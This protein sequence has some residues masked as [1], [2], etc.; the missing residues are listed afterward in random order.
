MSIDYSVLALPKGRPSKLEKADRLKAR[1]KVDESEN[2]K[3][4][5]RSGGRCEVEE[6]RAR[7]ERDGKGWTTIWHSGAR[8]KKRAVHIHH[9]LGGFGVRGRGKSALAENK[10]HT[11]ESCHS[12]IHA[13][14]LVPRGEQWIRRR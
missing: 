14:V 1:E 8:C 2:V 4:R 12:D 7:G 13:K 10:L 9:K 3:V 5:Q 6:V 11:C